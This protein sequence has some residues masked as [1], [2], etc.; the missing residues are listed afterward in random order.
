MNEH[1]CHDIPSPGSRRRRRGPSS[2]QMQDPEQVFYALSLKPGERFLDLGCGAGDYAF[3]ASLQVGPTGKVYGID[4]HEAFIDNLMD[5]A[6]SRG[7]ANVEGKI[8][9]ICRKID[10]PDQSIDHCLIS[11]VLHALDLEESAPTLFSEIHRILKPGAHLS[12][13]ECQKEKM[14]FGPPLWMRISGEELENLITPYGFKQIKYMNL[15][16]NYL[17]QFITL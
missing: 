8:C 16:P 4:I 11:T 7:L 5:E 9:N 2:Y 13:I 12:I 6:C 17:I 14:S 10:L 1:P 15:G 3:H